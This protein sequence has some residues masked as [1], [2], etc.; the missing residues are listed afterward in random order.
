MVAAPRWAHRLLL[1]AWLLSPATTNALAKVKLTG[2][3]RMRTGKSPSSFTRFGVMA[4]MR[5]F[6]APSPISALHCAGLG[7][8]TEQ[9]SAPLAFEAGIGKETT[10]PTA[11]VP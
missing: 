2:R 6:A 5:S 10:P 3:S 7:V 4:L 9:M 1:G 11:L 8:A